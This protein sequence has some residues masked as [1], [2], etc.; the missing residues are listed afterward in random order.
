MQSEDERVALM[1]ADKVFERAWG[2]PKEFDPNAEAPKKAPPF[3]PSLYSV[4]ELKQM[5][6]VML[7]IA[8]R[9]GLLPE[10]EGD[11]A[12]EPAVESRDERPFTASHVRGNR[13]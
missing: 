8:R 12:S 1:A 10:E 11:E 3:D 7:M 9:E 2:K 4:E 13:G 6:A 5:Q